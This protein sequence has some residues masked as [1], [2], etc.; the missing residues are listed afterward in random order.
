MPTAMVSGETLRSSAGQSRSVTAG[1]VVSFASDTTQ[2]LRNRLAAVA[3]ILAVFYFVRFLFSLAYPDSGEGHAGTTFA[4]RVVLSIAVLS[5]VMSR[6]SL[7]LR[8][9]RVIE[10]IFFGVHTAIILHNVY[11]ITGEMIAAGDPTSAIALGKNCLVRMLTLM[12]LYGVLI[13]NDPRVAARTISAMAAGLVGVLVLLRYQL[14]DQSEVARQVVGGEIALSNAL[15]VILGAGVSIFAAH[16][17]NHLRRELC[18]AKQLGQYRLGTKLGEGG[19]GKVYMAEH[20]HLKRP[21]AVKLISPDLQSNAVALARFEREV[22]SSAKLSHPNT[23][24]IFD[25]GRAE[26]G[27]FYY[28]MEYLPGMSLW[29]LVTQYGPT[30]PGRAVYITRQVCKSLSEAHRMGMVHRDLKPNNIH[31]ANLGGEYDVAKVLDFGLVKWNAD[32][33]APQLTAEHSVSGTPLFMSPEQ[34]T[35]RRDIDG[36]SDLYALGAV[37]Y[38]LLTGKPPF[39]GNNAIA[40]LVAHASQAAVPP[41]QLNPEIPDDLEAVVLKCLAKNAVDRFQDARELGD[42]LAACACA[43]DWNESAAESWW[44]A[45]SNSE[46]SPTGPIAS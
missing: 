38:F 10:Y 46:L 2:L 12:M 41:S 19:M 16:V 22:Q 13:P 5:V 18:D 40:I 14:F 33:E 15:Y 1:M 8:N 3:I 31:L 37:L 32:P 17:L 36:R 21:C 29:D 23:I 9:L 35:G 45:Q 27:T 6:L 30:S 44:A 34:A 7:T 20:R 25:Y 11:S 43:A 26:D 4:I 42:A 28:V 24:E 39:E